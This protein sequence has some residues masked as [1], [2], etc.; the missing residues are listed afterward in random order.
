MNH[1]S[2]TPTL[3][4][5]QKNTRPKSIVS[6]LKKPKV[7]AES[8]TGEKHYYRNYNEKNLSFVSLIIIQGISIVHSVFYVVTCFQM[9]HL[10]KIN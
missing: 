6:L 7:S 3:P 10:K 2:D 8:D 5:S 9:N 1:T 4:P